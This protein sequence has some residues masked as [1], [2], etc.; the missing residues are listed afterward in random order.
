MYKLKIVHYAHRQHQVPSSATRAETGSLST[1]LPSAIY[2]CPLASPALTRSP[3][4]PA[5]VKLTPWSALSAT[6]AAASYQTACFA[7]IN[8]SAHCARPPSSSIQPAQG[9]R[10]APHVPLTIST[11]QPAIKPS[12]SAALMDLLSILLPI[13][14]KLLSVLVPASPAETMRLASAY[15]ALMDI[16]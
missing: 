4:P 11:A 15:L 6:V 5:S 12:A 9:I 3:A 8:I 7:T 16:S 2:V 1:Q 14:A 10:S 13:S